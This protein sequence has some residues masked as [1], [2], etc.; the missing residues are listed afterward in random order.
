MNHN[1][2]TSTEHLPWPGLS[3]FT[4]IVLL[5]V[6]AFSI[7]VVC[8]TTVPP[9]LWIDEANNGLDALTIING[10]H[11][12]VY[13]S[14]NVGQE[15]LF[16]YLCALS[17]KIFGTN[18][19]AI[20]LVSVLIGALAVPLLFLFV[21]ELFDGRTIALIAALLL[22]FSRWHIHFSRI[23]FRGIF[24]PTIVLLC[25]LFLVR[26]LKRQHWKYYS[27][28]GITTG[29]GFYTYISFR[30]FPLILFIFLVHLLI[31]ERQSLKGQSPRIVLTLFLVVAVV[32]PL[33]VYVLENRELFFA[34]MDQTSIF[35]QSGNLYLNFGSNILRYALMFFISGDPLL[36][37]NIPDQPMLP[38]ILMPFL[39]AGIVIFVKQIRDWRFSLIMAN[40]GVMLLPGLLS[41]TTQ[42][43][44]ALRTLGVTPFM[45]VFVAYALV[46][47]KRLLPFEERLTTVGKKMNLSPQTFSSLIVILI[48]ALA[49]LHE[50]INYFLV[51]PSL[52]NKSGPA[53]RSFEAFN[54]DEIDIARAINQYSDRADFYVSPQ[55]F[56]HMTFQY[57]IYQ[58]SRPRMII[59]HDDLIRTTDKNK[60]RVFVVC[61]LNRNLWWL[62]SSPVKNFF[63]WSKRYYNLTEDD[64]WEAK[65][66]CYPP[67][68]HFMSKSDA[69]L[70]DRIKDVY[71]RGRRDTVGC[72]TLYWITE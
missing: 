35:A 45:Y 43:P 30:V 8:L 36:R 32:L 31:C 46:Q 29:L 21:R 66:F 57:F 23:G 4:V 49:F 33:A 41:T 15:A 50:Q 65:V 38:Y 12:P 52:V 71:P 20:R 55:L 25:L 72:Y 14:S 22:L 60:S 54:T 28:L 1:E 2:I 27:L 19:L 16:K 56:L 3:D 10:W 24:I 26:A 17:I 40:F 48:L 59:N 67:G 18:A 44:A 70:L 47:L 64:I 39:V 62:R 34:R 69:Y 51:W 68:I 61:T 42:S 7:R 9:G 13:F 53:V 11:Y 6:M 37:H 58:K 5:F 63:D